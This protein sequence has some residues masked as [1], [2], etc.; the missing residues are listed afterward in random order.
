MTTA[1]ATKY[2]TVVGVEVHVQLKTKS[3]LFCPDSTTFGGDPNENTCIVCLGYPGALPVLNKQAVD[4]AIMLGLALNCNIAPISKFDRKHYFYPDLPKA[5]QISQFDM[6]VCEHGH[7][8]LSTGNKVRILRAHLEEDAGKL[9][10][11]GAE[12]LAG[13]DYSMSDLN[14]AGTPLL[15]IVSEP[16][17]RTGEEAR[18]YMTNLRNIVRY[19]GVCDG[20]L[21][22]G[23]M[24]CDVNV[25]IRPVGQTELGTKAEVKN[26]NSLRAIQKAVEFETQR[27]AKILDEGGFVSQDTRLWNDA[28]QETITMRTKEGAADYR[29]FPE[30]DLK[31]LII[32]SEWIESVR[33]TLPELPK[34]RL[35]KLMTTYSLPDHDANLLVDNKDL[36]DCFEAAVN[37]NKNYKALSNWLV[38]DIMG[39]LKTE[40][41]EL[42]ELPF[43][44]E[45]LAE[46]VQLLDEKVIGSA[47]AKK[48]LPELLEKGG[49]PKA[50]V[51]KRGMAQV[52]D[53]GALK[54]EIQKVID[55]NPGQVEQFKAGKD[56]LMGFFVGQIMKATKGS[57]NPEVVS[58]LIKE[59]L[60]N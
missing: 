50:I 40:K 5:Y 13:S 57:A 27:Q 22:E 16:D 11:A 1:V 55:A 18:E 48:L 19:L 56:K 52:S 26:M 36:G 46:L 10:H 23:S 41:K 37:H 33:K 29:Y 6:P 45:T 25:S 60:Q 39:W 24:R 44:G 31:P 28:T 21:E 12:G 17:I 4:Y 32:S 54:T 38:G 15:E 42:A 30:P 59:M 51:D 2:E 35:E 9:V 7:M 53:E 34:Q 47:I 58:K 14:R 3:K 49:S 43:D 8:T 20:N